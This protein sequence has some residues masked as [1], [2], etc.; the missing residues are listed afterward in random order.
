MSQVMKSPALVVHT[1]RWS[2]S[3]KIVDLFT[4]HGLVRLIA[5]GALRAKSPFRGVLEV[6][7]EIEAV[8]HVR[9]TRGLQILTQATLLNSF[10]GIRGDL[11]KTAVAFAMLETLQKLLHSGEAFPAFY[12][13][14]VQLFERLN[15]DA[16][17][18]P[19]LYLWHFL[20]RFSNELGF[21]LQLEWC[22]V[23]HQ[24]PQE[25]PVWFRT[26]TGAVVC[27]K[28]ASPTESTPY[29]ELTASEYHLLTQLQRMEYPAPSVPELPNQMHRITGFLLK[30]LAHHTDIPLELNALKWL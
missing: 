16:Q 11:E 19:V 8:W 23:C 2:E 29:V 25:F 7:N 26:D 15:K 24:V 27:G 17:T 5:K 6:L 12:A 13:Y 18:P 22:S 1:R 9:E 21:A 3:S 4:P 30:H 20:I 14:L 10:Q 28:C